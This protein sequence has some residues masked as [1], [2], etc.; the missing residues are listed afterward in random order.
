MTAAATITAASA[1]RRRPSRLGRLALLALV[2][3]PAATVAADDVALHRSVR[4]GPD[5]TVVRL[6]DVAELRGPDAEALAD[7]EIATLDDAGRATITVAAI[8]RR[9]TEAGA[10]WGRLNLSGLDVRVSRRH[11][12]AAAAMRPMRLAGTATPDTGDG[13]RPAPERGRR[14]V[15]ATALAQTGTVRAAIVDRFLADLGVARDDLR[16]TFDGKDNPFLDRPVEGVTIEPIDALATAAPRL[17]LIGP[18]TFGAPPE[19]VIVRPE[20]RLDLAV[21]RVDLERGTV[22]VPADLAST[23]QWVR[24]DEASGLVTPADAAGMAARRP[25]RVGQTIGARDVE[26][27]IVIRRGDTVVLECRVNE[28][29]IEMTCEAAEHGSVGQ[30][31]ELRPAGER[32]TLTAVVAGPGRAVRTVGRAATRPSMP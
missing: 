31:I 18:G 9:L 17:R 14:L 15:E 32:R 21:A 3:L 7:V 10:H 30:P 2:L 16:L 23:E 22:I 4:V 20:I 8:R 24:P 13:D 11:L 27:P 28:F 19:V 29:L 5:A 25:L 26:V 6:G 12:P 1:V